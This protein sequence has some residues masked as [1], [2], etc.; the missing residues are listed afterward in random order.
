VAVLLRIDWFADLTFTV[1]DRNLISRL[2]HGVQRRYPPDLY[3]L[4]CLANINIDTL[5][6]ILYSK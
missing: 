4:H 3:I 1:L 6:Y 2:S 5:W